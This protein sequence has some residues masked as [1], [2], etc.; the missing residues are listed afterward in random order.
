M[1]RPAFAFAALVLIASPALADLQVRMPEVDY[2]EF[3]FEH[4]GLV[5]F[6]TKGSPLHNAQSYT[7]SI[8][9]GV[10]PWWEIELEGEMAVRRRPAPDLE[11]HHAGEHL[12]DHRARRVLLQPRLLLR[13]FAIHAARRAQR[14]HLRADHPEGA[15]RRPRPRHAAHAQPVPVARCR[16][17]RDEGHRL[18]VCLAVADRDASADL[19]RRRVLRHHSRPGA[20]RT[21]NAAAALGRSGAGRRPELR[22]VRRTEI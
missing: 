14:R 2:G 5:T 8:G 10:L 21:D 4:N 7:N 15:E 9:Y 3:E 19:A 1:L 16:A 20:C 12:P 6:D 18:P 13:I 11:C 22:T 17:R